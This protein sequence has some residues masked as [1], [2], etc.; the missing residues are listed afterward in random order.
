M[1]VA[2]PAI[3]AG[4]VDALTTNVDIHATLADVFDAPSSH[5][6][7]GYSLVPLLLG[8]TSG[9]RDYV[10]SGIWGKWVHIIDGGRKYARGPAGANAPLS[11]WSNRW[12]TMPV[13]RVPDLRLPLPDKRARLDFMPGSEVPVIRQPFDAGDRLPYWARDQKPGNHLWNLVD[14]PDEER[15]LVGT[16]LEKDA[17]EQLRAAL[18]EV[19]APDDQLGRLG[20]E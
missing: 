3:P 12:S 16:P 13:H 15:D 1:L 20:L 6:R 7:H 9:I 4:E 18:L 8:E 17:E 10:L 19:A 11:M 14:D 2:W 5:R